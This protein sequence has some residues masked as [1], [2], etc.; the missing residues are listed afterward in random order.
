[1]I[2]HPKEIVNVVDDEVVSKTENANELASSENKTIESKNESTSKSSKRKKSVFDKLDFS[3][4][5][6]SDTLINN[7]SF[8]LFV[9][10]LA[11][12]Y[13]WNNHHALRSINTI[14]QNEKQLK[15][16]K[17]EYIYSKSDLEFKSKQSEVAKMLET[18]GIK[19][20]K[21]PPTKIYITT[22][23]GN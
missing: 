23:G 11:L 7:L 12:M 4:L 6:S 10:F 22:N 19:E 9:A 1:M 18:T 5:I 16:L 2:K 20:L 8:I 13:I 15:Q 17:W 21:N 14:N 3:S